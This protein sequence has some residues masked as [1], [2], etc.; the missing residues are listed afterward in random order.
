VTTASDKGL[1]VGMRVTARL[2]DDAPAYPGTVV[3]IHPLLAGDV[4]QHVKVRLDARP[5]DWPYGD[6]LVMS[7]RVTRV[8]PLLDESRT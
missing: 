4:H 3:E 5:P 1:T 7:P 2:F 8:D 6:D